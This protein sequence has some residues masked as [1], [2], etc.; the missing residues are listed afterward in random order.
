MQNS[1]HRQTGTSLLKTT[2]INNVFQHIHDQ[3]VVAPTV[4]A[5]KSV[6]FICKQLYIEMLIKRT[7]NSSR[8]CIKQ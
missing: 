5:N 2:F 6:A 8:W 1:C 4:K 7:W 3:F